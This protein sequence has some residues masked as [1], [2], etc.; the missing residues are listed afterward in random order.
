MAST[1]HHHHHPGHAHPSAP[2]PPSILRLSAWLRLAVA[3]VLV[4]L[5]WAAT[6]WV[7]GTP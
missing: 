1:H 7:T 4:A 3:L 5:V 6:F 2:I